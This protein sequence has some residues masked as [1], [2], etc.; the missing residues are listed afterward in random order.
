SPLAAKGPAG[1]SRDAR[2][3]RRRVPGA[4][5]RPQQGAPL[6]GGRGASV[7][8][9]PGALAGLALINL[10]PTSA[11]GAPPGSATPAGPPLLVP[12]SRGV[13]CRRRQRLCQH[14]TPHSTAASDRSRPPGACT[15]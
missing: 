9:A 15:P 1:Q 4:S 11:T 3:P 13:P 8:L 2:G 14:K 7:L 12:G 10:P 6:L 5:V